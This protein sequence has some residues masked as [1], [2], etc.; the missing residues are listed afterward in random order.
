MNYSLLRLRFKSAVHFGESGSALSLY[1]SEDHFTADTLFSALCHTALSVFGTE[2]IERLA[3]YV[4][5]GALLLSDGMPYHGNDLYLPKPMAQSEL[6]T[7]VSDAVR[8]AMKR[9]RWIPVA[10]MDAFTRSLGSGSVFDAERYSVSFGKSDEVT[11]VQ[12]GASPYQVGLFRFAPDCGLYF[13]IGYADDP[14]YAEVRKLTALL[15]L[16]G[17][18]GKT[19]S[20]YGK[21]ELE[22]ERSF[23]TPSDSDTEWLSAAL[24]RT[25]GKALLIS[26][27]LPTE[28]EL[29]TA[30]EGANYQLC[31]KSGFI[32]SQ[33]Y[34]ETLRKKKTQ[35]FLNSGSVFVHRYSGALYDV[36]MGGSHP[37]YRYGK[38]MFVGVDL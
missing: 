8:K 12:V 10:A 6:R 21:F 9:L 31:R 37:V 15:G 38:A 11:K 5:N 36:S 25:E 29:E 13:I 4:R 30:L 1:T 28:E 23:D 26:S 18:G 24:R 35:Y 22:D 2:G 3:D 27:S 34:A 32:Y 7:E 20:G 16:D 19:S 14:L 17:I 33:T